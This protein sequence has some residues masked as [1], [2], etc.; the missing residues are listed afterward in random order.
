MNPNPA[1]ADKPDKQLDSEPNALDAPFIH[2]D[3]A[4]TNSFV[5]ISPR[6]TITK[7]EFDRLKAWL[8][9]QFFVVDS[10]E[11]EASEDN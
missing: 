1:S 9:D 6:S 8:E 4:K 10:G 11:H 2:I 3:L 7:V 5:L